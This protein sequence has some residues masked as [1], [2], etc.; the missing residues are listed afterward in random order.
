MQENFTL[1]YHHLGIPTEL[2]RSKERYSPRLKAYLSEF[3][4]SPYR[5]Q[6]MRFERDSSLP[7]IVKTIPHVAFEVE[8]LA[9]AIEGKNV[10]VEL[11]SPA[12]GVLAAFIEDDGA[13][14]EL[15]QID[16]SAK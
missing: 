1:I 11:H 3:E 13:P 14:V 16:S 2:K 15:L 8:N 4:E 7:T 5:I 9:K 6:W 12:N 10:I